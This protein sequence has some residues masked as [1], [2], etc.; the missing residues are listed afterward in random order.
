MNGIMKNI[1]LALAILWA[2]TASAKPHE[3]KNARVV[4]VETTVVSM[5]AW[6]DTNTIHY[7]IETDDMTYVLEYVFNPAV[8]APWP[9]QHSR[10]R[11]PNLT[12]NG[13]TKIAIDG[14]DAYIL[15]DDGRDVK[16]PIASKIA[17]TQPLAENPS[18]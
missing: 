18:K 12:V 11:S 1:A 8:K 17:R 5:A 16:L 4:S 13:K 3:W 2:T 10:T 9:G 6:G 7:K 14:R 15:D